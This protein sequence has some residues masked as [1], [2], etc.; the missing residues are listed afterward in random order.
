ME[1]RHSKS[2]GF[3]KRFDDKKGKKY[4]ITIW[5]YNHS[6]Q[7]G[8]ENVPKVDSYIAD[9][10]FRFDKEGKDLGWNEAWKYK[11]LSAKTATNI[12]SWKEYN[13]PG[14]W[15]LENS[16]HKTKGVLILESTDFLADIK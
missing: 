14:A 9:S 15:D 16:R 3:Q 13:I 11:I 7:L 10:Q 5:H 4:F 8:L 12:Y 1:T 2:S 6:E